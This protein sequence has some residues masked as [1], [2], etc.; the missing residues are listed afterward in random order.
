MKNCL[1]S[2]FLYLIS[3]TGVAQ[4]VKAIRITAS[5]ATNATFML[6]TALTIY[7]KDNLL[8]ATDGTQTVSFNLDGLKLD[9]LSEVTGIESTK[10]AAIYSIKDN[11][12]LIQ[13]PDKD[14]QAKVFSTSGQLLR[15][16]FPR[17]NDDIICISFASLSK[18]IYIIWC[19]NLSLKYQNR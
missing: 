4:N 7:F 1:L 16:E 2:I 10:A 18:G 11:M 13:S 12:L 9:Y 8:L 15:T 5:D 3:L 6:S 17:A 19:G 14:Q